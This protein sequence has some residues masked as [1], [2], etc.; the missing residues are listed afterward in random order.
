M[1]NEDFQEK[2]AVRLP[3]QGALAETG[4]FIWWEV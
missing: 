4:T 3:S 2:G 1:W